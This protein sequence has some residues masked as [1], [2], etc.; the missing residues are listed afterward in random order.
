VPRQDQESHR[1]YLS[2][3]FFANQRSRVRAKAHLELF[4]RPTWRKWP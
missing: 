2:F 3:A 4:L 1:K